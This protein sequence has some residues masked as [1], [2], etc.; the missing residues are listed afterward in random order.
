MRTRSR[1]ASE[2]LQRREAILD[3]AAKIFQKKGYEK[4]TMDDIAGAAKLSRTLLYV[5]F[6]DKDDIQMALALRAAEVLYAKMQSF[7]EPALSGIEAIAALGEAYYQ[8]YQC[9]YE[10]FQFLCMRMAMYT[11]KKRRNAK[12]TPT[13]QAMTAVEDQ[14]MGFMADAVVRGIEDGTVNPE[15]VDTPLQTA[16][17]LRGSL[18]GV[19]MLQDMTGSSLF[20]RAN[21]DREELIRYAMLIAVEE[22]A[23]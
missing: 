6:K 16:M 14:I 19:I 4:A 13:M 12:L 8:F 7:V 22:L 10:H 5:Y 17:Y 21:L 23:I 9:D 11:P 20:D 2:K 3:A 1:N 18:H 15:K